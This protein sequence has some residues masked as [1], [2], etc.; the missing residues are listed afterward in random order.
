MPNLKD[1][2]RIVKAARK[3]KLVIYKR[4]PIRLSADFSTE[5]LQIRREW[6]EIF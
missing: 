6:H 2:E 5:T 3:K 4:A 1:R